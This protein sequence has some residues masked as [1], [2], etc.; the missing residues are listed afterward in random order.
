MW[1]EYLELAM[2]DFRE[3]AEEHAKRNDHDERQQAEYD[4]QLIGDV[5]EIIQNGDS[6]KAIDLLREHN[7]IVDF[8]K[9]D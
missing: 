5:L 6:K 1:I 8:W 9:E 4:A 2:D 7:I 3:E